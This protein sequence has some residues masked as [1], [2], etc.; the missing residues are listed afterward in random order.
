MDKHTIFVKTISDYKC[1]HGCK[2][3]SYS[4]L[5]GESAMPYGVEIEAQTQTGSYK[6]SVTNF[7][8]KHQE[9]EEFSMFLYNNS[10]A[11]EHLNDIIHDFKVQGAFK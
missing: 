1:I 6:E 11:P 5:R 9:A 4:I 3:Y 2:K 8:S 7:L 10:V